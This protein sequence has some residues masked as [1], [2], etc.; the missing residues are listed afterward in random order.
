LEPSQTVPPTK[1]EVAKTPIIAYLPARL[2][3][4]L[5]S[6]AF[7]QGTRVA[8]WLPSARAANA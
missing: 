3:I 7:V 1:I 6:S 4:E 2:L 5:S 8:H